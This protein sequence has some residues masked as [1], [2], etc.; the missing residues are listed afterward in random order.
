MSKTTCRTRQE[1]SVYSSYNARLS[2]MIE[3]SERIIHKQAQLRALWTKKSLHLI[4][5]RCQNKLPNT[6]GTDSR[7]LIQR[8]KNDSPK[9]CRID[10]AISDS[11]FHHTHTPF[12]HW[13]FTFRTDFRKSQSFYSQFEF[14]ILEFGKIRDEFKFVALFACGG[15]PFPSEAAGNKQGTRGVSC[16]LDQLGSKLSVPCPCSFLVFLVVL[17]Y[18]SDFFQRKLVQYEQSQWSRD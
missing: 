13:L 12:T 14:W 10:C 16:A 7:F 17:S 5:A 11:P 15:I 8:Q 1:R 2:I 6:S 4:P 9:S 18:S 3:F